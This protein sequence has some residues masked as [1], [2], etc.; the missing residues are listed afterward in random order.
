MIAGRVVDPAR[1]LVPSAEIAVRHRATG[2]ERVVRA[3]RKGNYQ[4]AALPVGTYRVKVQAPGFETQIVE[5]ASVEVG[6]G[7]GA[8]VNIATR[9]GSNELRHVR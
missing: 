7:S 4:I 9:S 2:V 6:R 5:L 1:A 8:V 3:D